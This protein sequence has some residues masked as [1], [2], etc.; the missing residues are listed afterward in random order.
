MASLEHQSL[1]EGLFLV[2]SGSANKDPEGAI[3][4]CSNVLTKH[5]ATV[6]R[7]E[8]WAEQK[9]A[10]EVRKNK[11]GAYILTAFK[12]DTL[13]MQEIELECRLT[14][15]ILRY[16]FLNRDGVP[17]EKWF[18]RYEAPKAPRKEADVDLDLEVGAEIGEDTGVLID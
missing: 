2:D 3:E 17:I 18:R 11:R 6:I 10:Y 7:A 5:G 15:R 12:A 16:L 8:V 9:L 13:K 1:Y 14:E 4:L